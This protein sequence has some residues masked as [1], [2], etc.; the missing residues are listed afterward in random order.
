MA[1]GKFLTQVLQSK[2]H[3]G[4]DQGKASIKLRN[5]LDKKEASYSKAGSKQSFKNPSLFQ[6]Y[7]RSRSHRSRKIR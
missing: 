4:T 6:L 5:N 2:V 1:K 3:Q 7:A